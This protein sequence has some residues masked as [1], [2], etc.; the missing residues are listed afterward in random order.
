M[1]LNVARTEASVEPG[2]QIVAEAKLDPSHR[3]NFGI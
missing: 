1:S 2:L 3:A